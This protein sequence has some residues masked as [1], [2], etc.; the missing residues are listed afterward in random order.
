MKIDDITENIISNLG[1]HLKSSTPNHSISEIYDYAVLPPGKVF[2]PLLVWSIFSDFG[3]TNLAESI[4]DI[5]SPHNLF[6]AFV[7]THHAYTLVHDDLPCMDDD[8]E[9][10]GKASTHKKYGEWK[11]LLVGDGLINASYGMLSQI[12][13]NN[14]M[15]AFRFSTWCLGPKGLIQGQVLDLAEEMTINFESLILTHQNKTA[16]LMQTA[17][18][19]SFLI[20]DEVQDKGINR[21]NTSK[22]LFRLGHSI[23]VLFQ[24][25][26]D[27]TELVE[28]E[29]SSHEQ[30]VNPWLRFKEEC[31]QELTSGLSKVYEILE[32]YE[33]KHLNEIL[34]LYFKK[35]DTILRPNLKNVE[36]HVKTDLMPVMSLLERIHVRN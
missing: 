4:K 30:A 7:E 27:L 34:G 15:S 11:A 12:Q 20:L 13:A 9:R 35:I 8:D 17:L 31:F 16:R 3:K 10:R 28:E 14:I 33:M 23:G 36:S 25:L 2:R 1:T 18:V 29:I 26:D 19:G 32:K 22:D 21:Y 24:I 5:N 6:S